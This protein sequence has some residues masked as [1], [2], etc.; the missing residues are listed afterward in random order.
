MG[1]FLEAELEGRMGCGRVPTKKTGFFPRSSGLA[2]PHLEKRG[3]VLGDRVFF[4][5]GISRIFPL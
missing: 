4:Q 3:A 5:E 2:D 1:A